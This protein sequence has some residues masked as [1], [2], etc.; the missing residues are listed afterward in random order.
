MA[1]ALAWVLTL[2]AVATSATQPGADTLRRGEASQI[3][4]LEITS[5]AQVRREP[6]SHQEELGQQPPL[7]VAARK[8]EWPTAP[9]SVVQS[10]ASYQD[11]SGDAS[12]EGSGSGSGSGTG[13]GSGASSPEKIKEV[14][15]VSKAAEKEVSEKVDKARKEVEK[16]VG[17]DE[18]SAVAKTDCGNNNIK[19]SNEDSADI[20][21]I[22][23]IAEGVMIIILSVIICVILSRA[24]FPDEHEKKPLAAA[25]AAPPA[26]PAAAAA[27]AAPAATPKAT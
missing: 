27:P 22:A 13:S 14:T 23:V 12:G 7:A 8:H 4:A 3:A 5:G 15:K 11:T 10:T 2:L 18:K 6:A 25:Q 20:L 17:V 21:L 9:A 24:H 26:E 16:E 1:F 19:V